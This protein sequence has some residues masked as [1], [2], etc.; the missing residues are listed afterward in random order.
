[1]GKYLGV[2]STD[3]IRERKTAMCTTNVLS[4]G[5]W[6][7]AGH[8]LR[9]IYSTETV[10]FFFQFIQ[11]LY[12][13]FYHCFFKSNAL[14]IKVFYTWENQENVPKS[15]LKILNKHSWCSLHGCFTLVFNHLKTD[16]TL[17]QLCFHQSTNDASSIHWAGGRRGKKVAFQGPRSNGKS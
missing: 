12:T 7:S 1:M 6:R 16:G 8:I 3:R 17:A 9:N 15:I 4:G 14:S 13:Y 2:G 10:F 5:S 11:I